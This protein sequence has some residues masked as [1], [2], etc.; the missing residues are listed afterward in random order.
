MKIATWNVNSIRTRIDHV[1]KWLKLHPVDILCLQETKVE[2]SSFPR[3]QFKKAGYHVVC[4]GEKQFNGVAIISRRPLKVLGTTIDGF[5]TDDTRLLA[6]EYKGVTIYNVYFPS[7]GDPES[8]KFA[9]KLNFFKAFYNMINTRHDPM[10]DKVIVIGD[11]NIAPEDPDVYNPQLMRG[12]ISFHPEEH[13]VLQPFFEWGF[14]DL[15][16]LFYPLERGYYSWWNYRYLAF[17]RNHGLRIDLILVS[18][19]LI[20]YSSSCIIDIRPRTW[21]KPS[22]HAPCVGIFDLD[23]VEL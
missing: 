22:D 13:K 20:D 5:K 10:D 6:F 15:F 23:A 12:E 1:L 8:D 21:E 9:Y 19:T 4:H 7:G 11:F 3:E 18:P 2:N 17:K 16:R 14:E